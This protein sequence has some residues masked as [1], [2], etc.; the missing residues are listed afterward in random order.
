MALDDEK[1][2]LCLDDEL[3]EGIVGSKLHVQQVEQVLPPVRSHFSL[4]VCQ[5]SYA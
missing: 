5:S 4:Y 2:Y 1:R 3:G